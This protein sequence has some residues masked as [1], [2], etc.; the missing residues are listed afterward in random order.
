MIRCVSGWKVEIFF[1]HLLTALYKKAKM[2]EMGLINEDYAMTNGLH[3]PQHPPNKY[4]PRKFHDQSEEEESDEK[5]DDDDDDNY[6]D[7]EE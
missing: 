5:G 7:E 1:L 2:Q 4:A 6:D 3:M